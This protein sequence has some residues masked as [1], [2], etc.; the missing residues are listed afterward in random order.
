MPS[1]NNKYFKKNDSSDEFISDE[2]TFKINDFDGPLDLLLT[3]IKDK[4]I[5]IMEVNLLD[6]ANQYLNIIH[7]LKENQVDVAGEYLVMAATLIDLK[8]KM[9]LQEPGEEVS[10]EVEEQKQVLL[11]QLIEYQQFKEVKEVLRKFENERQNIY[12]KTPS[13]IDE[14]ILDTDDAKLD[15]HSNPLKL[16]SVLRKM[17]ERRYAQHLRET[18]IDNFNLTPADQF[19]H[20]KDLLS[21][22]EKLNFEEV[23]TLPSLK[24]FV[25]TLI[26]VLDLARQQVLKIVQD[27]QFDKIILIR[28]E[29]FDEK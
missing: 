29:Q 27:E 8:A 13:S 7:T 28:G 6:I 24:H 3:L 23:F 17:F 15:G 19:E 12:I 20:I 22:K 26:A 14:F 11:R 25:V 5:S 9:L 1:K 18:K 16:I 21:Q 2:Y 10:Q 4:K